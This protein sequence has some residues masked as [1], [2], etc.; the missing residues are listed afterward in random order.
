MA[1]YPH[2]SARPPSKKM[3]EAVQSGDIDRVLY[4]LTPRQRRFAEEYVID[5]DAKAAAIRAGY[6]PNA[7]AETGYT[8]RKHI[9]VIFYVDH[10][11]RSNASKIISV[12]P[13]YV[14]EGL[15]KML[16]DEEKTK[17]SDKIRIYEILARH[18]GMFIDRTEITGKD[19]G[20]VEIQRINEEAQ[21]FTNLMK[22][23][24]DRADKAKEEKTEAKLLD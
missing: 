8:L 5:Y 11:T 3:L 7:A 14:I 22:Q 1:N 4:R 23:L 6:S 15:T 17:H 9:G 20:A 21:S 13:D 24:Q 19:G 18:L 12:N 16:R 10:M 2:N